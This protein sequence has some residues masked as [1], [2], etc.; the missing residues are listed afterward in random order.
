MT[1]CDHCQP[2]PWHLRDLR[3]ATKLSGRELSRRMPTLAGR[4]VSRQ[5]LSSVERGAQPC[6]S[7]LVAVYEGLTDATKGVTA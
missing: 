2:P 1:R 4:A 3:E 7:W 6:P 5:F